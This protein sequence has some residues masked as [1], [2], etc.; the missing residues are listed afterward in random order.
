MPKFP[1]DKEYYIEIENDYSA[2]FWIGTVIH[3][4]KKKETILLNKIYLGINEYSAIERAYA[5]NM[6]SYPN[7][8]Q[9]KAKEVS[10][11]HG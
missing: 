4:H 10:L 9:Y 2:P 3:Y 1:P 7:R 5:E 11:H 8:N 6:T